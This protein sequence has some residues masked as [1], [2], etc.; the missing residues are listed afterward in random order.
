MPDEVNPKVSILLLRASWSR[1]AES[2]TTAARWATAGRNSTTSSTSSLTT[3]SL[4]CATRSY[5]DD[6]GKTSG[7]SLLVLLSFQRLTG[8]LISN[9]E[10]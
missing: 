6:L 4:R 10:V 7:C 2:S 9:E 1:A 3:L 8:V 5:A